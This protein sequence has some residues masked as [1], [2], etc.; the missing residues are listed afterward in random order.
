MESNLAPSSTDAAE[1][2]QTQHEMQDRVQQRGP[3]RGFAW[4]SLWS[5][6]IISAYI[7]ILLFALS[8]HPESATAANSGSFPRTGLL[9]VPLLMFV[10][11]I[12]GARERFGMRTRPSQ[13]F[14]IPVSAAFT[15]FITL[16]LLSL[17]EVHYPWLLN[18]IISATF[19]ATFTV[20]PIIQLVRSSPKGRAP[21]RG[22]VALSKPV[23][24]NTVI[25]GAF[26]GLLV[27]ISD[28]QFAF[29]ITMVIATAGIAV[30]LLKTQSN[31]GLAQAGYEW[32]TVHWTAFGLTLGTL[33]LLS[34]L[35][36]LSELLSTA[37]TTSVGITVFLVMLLASTLP[38]RIRPNA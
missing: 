32:S 13:K 10:S 21:L 25:I 12:T 4:L 34:L 22:T 15:A 14:W 2:L 19:L 9:L 6:L 1:Q 23:R 33:F 30:S 29:A 18:I 11:L 27:A 26:S 24:W 31:W 8:V 37:A 5:G 7:G 38:T 20:R 16:M 3:S 35:Y 36:P 28:Q 17:F